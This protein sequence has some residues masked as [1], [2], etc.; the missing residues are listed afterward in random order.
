MICEQQDGNEQ[1]NGSNLQKTQH[2]ENGPAHI[3]REPFAQDHERA[4]KAHD[5]PC[6]QKARTI[7]EPEN[8]KRSDEAHRGAEQP[9]GLAARRGTGYGAGQRRWGQAK[10]QKPKAI[11]REQKPDRLT[12][13]SGRQDYCRN[14]V[15]QC[16]NCRYQYRDT[17]AKQQET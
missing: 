4:A 16:D 8:A 11:R 9:T 14:A 13:N 3:R 10:A 17:A 12:G 5:L 7:L 1:C 15:G 6:D 2:K